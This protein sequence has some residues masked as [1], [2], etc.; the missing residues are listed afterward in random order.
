MTDDTWIPPAEATPEMVDAVK[1][2]VGAHAAKLIW[3]RMLEMALI[4]HRVQKLTKRGACNAVK[5]GEYNTLRCA[6]P[7]GHTGEH[8]YVVAD[9][10]PL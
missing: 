2:I 1:N 6:A 3:A 5:C 8:C 7:A 4:Q 10:G 9:K